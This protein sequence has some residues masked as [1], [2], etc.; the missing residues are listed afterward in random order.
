VS[1]LGQD[2]IDMNYD[3]WTEGESYE[4]LVKRYQGKG[5]K[6][7]DDTIGQVAARTGG[8]ASS[9]AA[10]A[11]Q[12][13]YGGWMENLENAA[14]SLYDTERQELMDRYNI[15]NDMYQ[16]DYQRGRDAIADQRYAT[17]WDYKISQD[18]QAT[19]DK[20]R[21]DMEERILNAAYYGLANWDD[22]F[23]DAKMAGM[24]KADFDRLVAQAQAAK[25]ESVTSEAPK[26]YAVSPEA[27]SAYVT[28]MQEIVNATDL[29]EEQK[30]IKAVRLM[31]R[32][33]SATGN[34]E[35]AYALLYSF[36]PDYDPEE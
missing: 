27:D 11:G 19:T 31:E 10:Q 29:T 21:E 12:Q 9:Y 28:K 25:Q 23:E 3:D 7:M 1:Q 32:I 18:T 22:M 14:R 24:T 16:R 26:F 8:L 15:A 34:S 2:L 30:E 35:Y 20:R 5:Q 13:A 33:L 6:A 4:S 36:F 17:E